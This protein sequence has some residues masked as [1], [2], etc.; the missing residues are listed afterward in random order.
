MAEKKATAKKLTA[1][2]QIK[3]LEERIAVLETYVKTFD[4]FLSN[5]MISNSVDMSANETLTEMAA[6]I[7]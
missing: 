4:T 5:T 1:A 2:V 7:N 3:A 6:N